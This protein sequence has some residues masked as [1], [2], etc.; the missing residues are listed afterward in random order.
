MTCIRLFGQ[1]VLPAMREIAR[2]LDLKSPFEA[3]TPVSLAF[4]ADLAPKAPAAAAE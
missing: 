2:E 4:S 1:E 3:A